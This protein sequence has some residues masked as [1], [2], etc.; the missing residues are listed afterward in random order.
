M[1][2]YDGEKD[3]VISVYASSYHF[4]S[5]IAQAYQQIKHLGF[6]HYFMIADDM[7]INPSINESNIFEKTGISSTESYIYDIR[8]MRN[9]FVPQHVSEMHKY[10][11]KVK[12][13]EVEKILPSKEEAER[14]FREHHLSVDDLSINYLLKQVHYAFKARMLRRMLSFGKD[15]LMHNVKINYPLVWGYSDILLLPDD[16][17]KTFSSYCGAFAAT[18]LFVEYAIPTSLVLSTKNIITDKQLKMHGVTQIYSNKRIKALN[19]C[20]AFNGYSPLYWEEE[21]VVKEYHMDLRY[22]LSHYPNDVFFIHP[23]KL[24]KWK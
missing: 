4:Q 15:V 16:T 2:F 11:V 21:K 13:V 7:I 3:N 19:K 12:G 9:C 23:I 20:N 17:M 22:L 6:T 10:R 18:G 8:E 1:P 14:H 24:S 5:Y